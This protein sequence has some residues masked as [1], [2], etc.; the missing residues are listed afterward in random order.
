MKSYVQ[1]CCLNFNDKQVRYSLFI[2]LD[3]DVTQYLHG[4]VEEQRYTKR[5]IKKKGTFN[6]IKT[7]KQ[8]FKK[9][10]KILFKRL[11]LLLDLTKQRQL[12]IPISAHH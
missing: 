9:R 4:V 2:F 8:A 3:L 10:A 7:K 6:I 11:I 5:L 1:L 12:K